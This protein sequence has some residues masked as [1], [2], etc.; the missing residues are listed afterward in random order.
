MRKIC[1]VSVN[2]F[3]EHDE[4]GYVFGA[5][6]VIED[7]EW[8]EVTDEEYYQ[9][10]KFIISQKRFNEGGPR[11]AIIERGTGF[12]S[13]FEKWKEQAK[14]SAEK[15]AKKEAMRL[16][17]EKSRKENSMKRKIK[18]AKELL[19]KAGIE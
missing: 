18:A 19:R 2:W 16:E 17:K 9:I 15:E 13:D 1:I 12:D 8:R 4:E 10:C 14:A 3:C 5:K 6:P 7:T 11:Y